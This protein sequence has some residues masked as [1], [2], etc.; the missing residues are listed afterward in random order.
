M[1]KKWKQLLI[2]TLAATSL[3]WQGG[4]VYADAKITDEHSSGNE[5][6]TTETNIKINDTTTDYTSET[7][8]NGKFFFENFYGGISGD[9]DYGTYSDYKNKGLISSNRYS[10]D[11]LLVFIMG[12]I[13]SSGNVT[14][15]VININGGNFYDGS[16]IYGGAADI[17]NGTA[18]ENKVTINKGTIR[19]V[20]G[21]IGQNAEN[22]KV[23]IKG[24]TVKNIY[25]GLGYITDSNDGE[26]NQVSGNTITINGGTITGNVYGGSLA[27]DKKNG[28]SK[29]SS[30][31]NNVINIYG[32]PDL[33]SANLYGYGGYGNHSGNTLNI[34]TKNLTANNIYKFDNLNFYLPSSTVNGDKILSLTATSTDLS[35][36]EINAGVKGGANLNVGDTITLVENQGTITTNSKTKYGTLSEGVSLKYKLTVEKSGDNSIIA[37]I[38]ESPIE[39]EPEVSASNHTVT[40]TNKNYTID[41]GEAT[42]YDGKS[43]LVYGG[44]ADGGKTVEDGTPTDKSIVGGKTSNS[45]SA[46]NNTV[47]IN[48][49]TITDG[50]IG[51]FSYDKE[52]SGN[53]ITING[54]TIS[55]NIYAGKSYSGNVLNN[56]INIY[57]NPKLSSA[58]L[59]GYSG[60]GEHSGN[61]LNVYSKNITANNI[62]NFD[63][64]NFYIPKSAKSGDVMLTLT[65]SKGTDISGAKVNAGVKGGSSLTTG[66]TITL[67]TN[68]NGLKTDG[69]TYGTLSEGVSFNYKLTVKKDG[70]NSVIAKIGKKINDDDTDE[71]NSSNTSSDS[72]SSYTATPTTKT[73]TSESSSNTSSDNTNSYTASPTTKSTSNS[74]TSTDSKRTLPQTKLLST[75]PITNLKIADFMSDKIIDWLPPS[76]FEFEDEKEDEESDNPVTMQ[77]EPQGY[78]VFIGSGGGSLRTKTGD[79][80]YIE[81]TYKGFNIGLGRNIGYSNGPLVFAPIFEYATGDYDS[82]ITGGI[83]G[84]GSMKYVAGG[85]ITRKTFNNGFYVEASARGGKTERDFSSTDMK[86]GNNPVFV[87]YDKT[88]APVFAGHLR[89]GKQF[90][91]NKNNLLD[92]YGIYFHTRQLGMDM[93]LSTGETYDFSSATSARTRLGYRLTTRTSKISRIYT[94]LAFQYEH[95]SNVTGIYKGYRTPS[96]GNYGLSGMVELGWMIKSDKKNPWMVDLNATGWLGHEQGLSGT[97]KFQ[98][99]F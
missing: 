80:S 61:T 79:G 16:W 47:K 76:S 51:G 24:G 57:G 41:D 29:N 5:I 53:T 74:S 69:T 83:H 59:Y 11:D 82:Y 95:T 91:L 67:I 50:V 37:K 54:G 72:K 75:T 34:Y 71:K 22:N 56:I 1:R 99:E 62:Y 93:K 45:E 58:N 55:G 49:G 43:D 33:S 70:D 39:P 17:N 86:Q 15:N 28:S 30:V 3:T 10:G 12:G 23:I 8:N 65:D 77:R 85:F 7:L 87:H 38:G 20:Y 94:G 40:V 73:S 88:S 48:S 63:T 6:T 32:S 36:T 52:V 84:K 25:G 96:A 18:S 19:A 92:V 64:L 81:S 27:F 97:F 21:G 46:S 78:E 68:E 90:R 31:I 89:V 35:N 2:A 44:Y 4:V 66:D 13:A 98:K 42:T 9:F 60:S 26:G 14:G